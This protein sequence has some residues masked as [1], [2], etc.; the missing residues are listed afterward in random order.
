M[1]GGYLGAA[2]MRMLGLAM[3]IG[4]GL[5][6]SGCAYQELKAPCARDEGLPAT[7]YAEAPAM[8]EP[9][10]SM[11]R[12]GALRPLNKGPLNGE[13]NTGA[14]DGGLLRGE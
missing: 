10:A 6:L 4:A 13:M 3:L 9:F 2:R 7:S 12:C 1:R 8:P 5:C 14:G 11:Y